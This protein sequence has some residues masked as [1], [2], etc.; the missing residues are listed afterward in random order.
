MEG[1][2]PATPAEPAS[3]DITKIEIAKEKIA[4]D[5][6]DA[7]FFQ[8]QIFDISDDSKTD[9]KDCELAKLKESFSHELKQKT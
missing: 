2:C 6:D 8:K 4:C 5:D 1:L 3:E 7:I 9:E